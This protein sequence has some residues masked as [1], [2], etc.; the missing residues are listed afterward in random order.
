MQSAEEK[1]RSMLHGHF[2]AR[3]ARTLKYNR[4]TRISDSPLE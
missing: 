4:D 3:G 1:R 2:F